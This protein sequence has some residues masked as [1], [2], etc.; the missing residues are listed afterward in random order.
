[1]MLRSFV[2]MMIVLCTRVS[3][4]ENIEVPIYD[5]NWED[6]DTDYDAVC[7]VAE[8]EKPSQVT[9]WLRSLG[10]ALYAGICS[11]RDYVVAKYFAIR[12]VL[13][14]KKRNAYEKS[15]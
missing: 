1:M 13:F 5:Y 14:L 2:F 4:T 15:P 6:L 9:V 3:G 8:Y 11:A 10:G 12:K 7:D